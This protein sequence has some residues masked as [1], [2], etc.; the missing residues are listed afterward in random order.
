MS[1]PDDREFRADIRSMSRIVSIGVWLNV[2]A[3]MVLHLAGCVPQMRPVPILVLGG[4]IQ[5]TAWVTFLSALT[6][7]RPLVLYFCFH[8][9]DVLWVTGMIYFAGGWACPHPGLFYA[10]IVV[11]GGVIGG[12]PAH[13]L[14]TASVVAYGSM[15]LIPQPGA[16]SPAS[17]GEQVAAVAMMA[18][19]LQLIAAY[20]GRLAGLLNARRL[21]LVAAN[22]ELELRVRQRTRELEIERHALQAQRDRLRDV[23]YVVT[24]DLKNPMNAIN[25]WADLALSRS[26]PGR[27]PLAW[28]ALQRIAG[29]AAETEQKIAD[30]V[31]LFRITSEAEEACPVQLEALVT[32]ALDVLQPQLADKRVRL[33]RAALPDVWGRSAKLAHVVMNLLS[34]AVKYV[35]S[36]GLICIDGGRSG[37]ETWLCVADNGIGVA[38]QYQ[39]RIFELFRRA[40]DSEQIVDG[41]PVKGTGVG[42]A[43]VRQ[44]VEQHGGS[45]RVQSRPGAGARFEVRLPAA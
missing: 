45:V 23:L 12:T 11:N 30:L 25:L 2:A 3:A 35:P 7:R 37:R 29:Q 15:L 20:T 33:R 36:G 24:H 6:V 27:A 39:E 4:A 40:P 43:L 18:V 34:N 31:E 1:A 38:E 19:G 32:K 14:A 8:L 21:A 42:L 28:S 41:R 22:G 26:D 10:L 9:L 44:I 13:V 17:P 16:L 5:V